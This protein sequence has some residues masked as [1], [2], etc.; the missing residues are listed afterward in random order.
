MATRQRGRETWADAAQA[1]LQFPPAAGD[2][3]QFTPEVG[4]LADC[5][6]SVRVVRQLDATEVDA[7]VGRMYRVVCLNGGAR[8]G[9]E[10]DAYAE[11][12]SR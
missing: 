4:A 11:E 12:L 10:F 9:E 7:E 3:V 1:P 6:G 8:N 5:A 2:V